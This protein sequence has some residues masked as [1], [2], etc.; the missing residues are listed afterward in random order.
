MLA[1]P[2]GKER[3]GGDVHDHADTKTHWK[4][5]AFVYEITDKILEKIVN[6]GPEKFE[7]W[8][9]FS[10]ENLPEKQLYIQ[11]SDTTQAWFLKCL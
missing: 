6:P 10:L 2:F 8:E 5:H 1:H 4:T 11:V 3:Q 7:T 9:W